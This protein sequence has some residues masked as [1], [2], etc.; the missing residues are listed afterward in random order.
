L[1]SEF[2]ID[3]R[4]LNDF[5][6]LIILI[7]PPE[8]P[9]TSGIFLCVLCRTADFSLLLN[10]LICF[11]QF[12]LKPLITF[13]FQLF[14]AWIVG[15]TFAFVWNRLANRLEY[16]TCFQCFGKFEA[17]ARLLDVWF[18]ITFAFLIFQLFLLLVF[19]FWR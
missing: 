8:L 10:N 1:K 7:L 6:L 9:I 18:L 19:T 15:H 3:S 13:C 5:I 4:R 12:R 14:D 17:Y 2:I 16:L 11:F